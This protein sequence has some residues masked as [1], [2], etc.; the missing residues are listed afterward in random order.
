MEK[1]SITFIQK[2]AAQQMQSQFRLYFVSLV[3][4][5]FAASIH[6]A[7]LGSSIV[8]DVTEIFGWV[9]FLVCGLLALW[10]LEQ[11]PLVVE[12]YANTS[13]LEQQL[14]EA[15]TKKLQGVKS[16][17]VLPIDG[18]QS[19]EDRIS[20]LQTSLGTLESN[21]D[22]H[23]DKIGNLYD[24]CKYAFIAGLIFILV[25]RSAGTI[26]TLLGFTLI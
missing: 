24:F 5:L 3:F 18:T 8:Q 10:Y 20:N 19:I 2:T 14:N 11:V 13:G 1:E 7:K 21:A 22:K 9:C 6:T 25:S 15:K 23:L 17:Y 12:K 16:I 26:A 4:T